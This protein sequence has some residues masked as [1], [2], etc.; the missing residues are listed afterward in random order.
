MAVADAQLTREI[1]ESGMA[2][3]AIFAW[4]DEWFKKNWIVIDFEIP[5]E[6]KRLWLNRLDAEEHYG[7]L[8]EEPGEILP[9]AT[10]AQRLDAWRRRPALYS[11][12]AGT[13]RA[14]ADEAY[15]W[16]E[17]ETADGR[18]PDDLYL[19][20]D[21]VDPARGDFRWPGRV[22]DRL[23]VGLEFALHATSTEARLLADPPSNPI[24]VDRVEQMPGRPN[25]PPDIAN[26]LPGYFWGRY[27]QRYNR[28][29]ATRANEDG[30]YDSLRVVTNRR[31]FGR[32]GTEYPG[33]GY[34][35]GILRPGDPPDG[36][37]EALPERGVFEVRIPWMLLNF[38][39]PSERRVLQDPASGPLPEEYGTV[40][41]PGIRIVAAAREGGAWRSWPAANGQAA[42]FTWPTWEVPRSRER[43]RPVYAAMRDVFRTLDPPVTH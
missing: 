21:V 13:V 33:F 5:L 2:G 11:T 37:W 38:T 25:P 1:A 14:A 24:A 4:I 36:L 16:V 28:P 3:G 17:V 39:D 29:F 30:V 6:R 41:V 42:L 35:R 15:L 19:G 18:A 40:T 8:A 9:G 10:L 27:Q 43:E 34:D 31:R 23:P 26:P 12:P 22:G 32:D 20:F 7:M